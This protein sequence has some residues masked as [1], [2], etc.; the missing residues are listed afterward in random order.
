MK[1]IITFGFLVCVIILTVIVGSY[2]YLIGYHGEDKKVTINVKEGQ[3]Y[4]TISSLLKEK[5]IVHI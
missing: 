1:K 3:T 4:S 2:F 5:N